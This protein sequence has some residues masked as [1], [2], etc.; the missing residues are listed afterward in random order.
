MTIRKEVQIEC[1]KCEKRYVFF[2][3]DSLPGYF[4]GYCMFNL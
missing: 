1:K 3:S 4:L 2:I